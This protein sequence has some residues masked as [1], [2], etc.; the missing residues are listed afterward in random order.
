MEAPHGNPKTKSEAA[1]ILKFVDIYDITGHIIA[2]LP[3]KDGSATWKPQ[4]E[5]GSGI[6]F[7]SIK[8]NGKSYFA[9]LIYIK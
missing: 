5:I 2:K 7:A 9:K 1:Y 4:N 3:T 8:I 6:Y